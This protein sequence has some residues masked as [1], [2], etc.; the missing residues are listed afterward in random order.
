MAAG[1]TFKAGQISLTGAAQKLTGI[2]SSAGGRLVNPGATNP[3]Y[4][5][6]DNTVSATTGYPLMPGRDIP[7]EVL[8]FNKLWVF[9]TAADKL[10]WFTNG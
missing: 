5:G 7:I 9:G 10:G 2:P 8:S 1:D 4:I 6:G 3:I